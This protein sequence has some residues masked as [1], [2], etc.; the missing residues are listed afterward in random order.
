MT[1]NKARL[2]RCFQAVFPD[3]LE[4]EIMR[5]AVGR[6]AT[7]DSVATATLVAAVEEEFTMQFDVSE[8]ENLN[9]F[10]RFAERLN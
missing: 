1:D 8:I 10:Q 5:A 3:L 7:W 4:G 9:S 2:I 6:T